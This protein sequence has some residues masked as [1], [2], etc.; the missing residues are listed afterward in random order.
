[1]LVAAIIEALGSSL[2]P[3]MLH[4]RACMLNNGTGYMD[5]LDF[6]PR[7]IFFDVII[8]SYSYAWWL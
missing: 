1:M 8:G 4:A 7:L 6:L 5:F 3:L 2:L